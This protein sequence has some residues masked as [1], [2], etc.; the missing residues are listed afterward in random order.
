MM[1]R[2]RPVL[3]DALALDRSD[4]AGLARQ[5]HVELRRMI[6]DGVLP[7]A[8]RLPSSRALARAWGIARN[9]VVGALDRLA[10]EGLL[11]SR[12]G[13]GTFVAE[14]VG[15]RLPR[16]ASAKAASGL[17]AR[18][19]VALTEAMLRGQHG[20]R[21][22]APDVP[23]L[24]R[25]PT[26]L[27][28]RSILRSARRQ[29]LALLQGVDRR[30]FAP[31][32]AAIAAHVGPARG[33][34]CAPEQIV[35]LT[36]TRQAIQLAGLLLTE[37]GEAVAIEDPGYLGARAIFS[38]AGLKLTAMPVDGEG[39]SAER[40]AGVRLIYLTPSHQYPLGVA[41]S[42]K[43][44]MAALGIAERL[45]AWIVEDDYD[46]EFQ[47]RG[48]PAPSLHGLSGGGRVLYA[49]TFSKAMF[50]AIRLAYL[51][52]PPDLID[53][54][55]SVRASLDGITQLHGQAA[56]ADF[57]ESGA[58]AAHIRRMRGLYAEREEA[59]LDRLQ[60]R[61]GGLLHLPEPGG[62]L[63]L[64]ALFRRSADDIDLVRRLD[65][66]EAAP[67]PLSRYYLKDGAAGLLM[68]FAASTPAVLGRAVDHL[69][70]IIESGSGRKRRTGTSG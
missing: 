30:G 19:R 17:S 25:F 10:A 18:G 46:G 58:F 29:R 33:V 51:V 24:D 57:M 48:H 9:T 23:A 28:H 14:I 32:R 20:D 64:A 15:A 39:A 6:L 8:A 44:R 35:I 63:Q 3:L 13:S 11:A 45:D 26:D 31:L 43:R 7:A 54:F 49:G 21:P 60:A 34:I 52:V 5:V 59:L 22:L 42:L 38:A 61:L 16:R 68:G 50:P 69:A 65:P 4:P 41:M 12:R 37:P 36:S 62:G 66:A 56:L 40:L 1:I 67:M 53:A 70:R 2:R 55:A 27:W 47:I